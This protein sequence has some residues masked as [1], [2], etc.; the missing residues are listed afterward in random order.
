[1]TPRKCKVLT[2][3]T[4][5]M[6][7]TYLS[8]RWGIIE[9]YSQGHSPGT[10]PQQPLC[11]THVPGHETTHMWI[12]HPTPRLMLFTPELNHWAGSGVFSF[13]SYQYILP[14][15][16]PRL[17]SRAVLCMVDKAILFILLLFIIF[18]FWILP[19]LTEASMANGFVF[20]STL[21]WA[22]DMLQLKDSIS[23][24]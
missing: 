17:E 6:R 1:M 23:M 13:T 20:Y 3:W 5:Q 21:F 7:S 10:L 22:A 19:K 16:P 11:R 15:P 2:H 4:W 14:S 18:V 12:C 8:L 9:P 24:V